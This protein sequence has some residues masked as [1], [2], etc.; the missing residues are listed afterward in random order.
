MPS[1]KNPFDEI[2]RMFDRMASQFEDIDDWGSF[3]AAMP[4]RLSVDVAEYDDE[5]VV[6]T[7]LPGFAKEDIDVEL[8]EDRLRIAAEHIEDVETEEPERYVRQERRK[9][10]QSRTITLPEPVEDDG[11]SATFNNGVL[12]VTLPKT[13]ISDSHSIDIE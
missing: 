2:Q 1:R 9:R 7:D 13:G 5:F 6:T 8:S 11:V 10:S 12:T 4:G 3:E